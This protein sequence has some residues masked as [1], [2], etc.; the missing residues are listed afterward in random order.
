MP[1]DTADEPSVSIWYSITAI[2]VKQKTPSG[3]CIDDNL[4]YLA[5]HMGHSRILWIKTPI[6]IYEKIF[7]NM[8]FFLTA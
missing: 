1:K 2:C 5:N 7:A 8:I 6:F 4:G 3:F